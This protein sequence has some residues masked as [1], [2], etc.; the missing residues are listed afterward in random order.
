MVNPE[1]CVF[2]FPLS[3]VLSF[4]QK[5]E[6]A[7]FYKEKAF[8]EAFEAEN[9]SELGPILQIRASFWRD[10]GTANGKRNLAAVMG[11]LD[12]VGDALQVSRSAV[13]TRRRGSCTPLEMLWDFQ[14][15]VQGIG[16]EVGE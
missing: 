5:L 2:W 9:E 14:V 1:P 3:I 13:P 8:T 15:V 7:H 16:L 10:E 12:G 11:Q 6:R 4:A